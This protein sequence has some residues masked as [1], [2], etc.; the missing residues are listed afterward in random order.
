MLLIGK[1]SINGPCSMAVFNN[2]RV[3]YVKMC[4]Y[5]I[6]MIIIYIYI[7]ILYN[8]ILGYDIIIQ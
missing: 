1:P 2:Q 5:V 3:I 4:Y 6:N 8:N 7:I